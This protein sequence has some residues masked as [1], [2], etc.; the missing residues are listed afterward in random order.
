M[1]IERT[2]GNLSQIK[3]VCRD[4]KGAKYLT[5]VFRICKV[6][7]SIATFTHYILC[8]WNILKGICEK[9]KDNLGT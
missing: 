1:F 5:K 8:S 3:M 6:L 9:F 7:T 2:E 4:M